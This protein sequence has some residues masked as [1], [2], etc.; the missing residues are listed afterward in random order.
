MNSR[1]VKSDQ[2]LA[3]KCTREEFRTKILAEIEK[4]EK[5]FSFNELCSRIR[6][7]CEFEK[8]N[9]TDY[10][11]IIDFQRPDTDYINEIIWELIWNKKLMIDFT[12]RTQYNNTDMFNFTKL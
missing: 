8:D 2:F 7:L 1:I 6:S 12:K 3:L 5:H 9:D 4:S 11:D 10:L